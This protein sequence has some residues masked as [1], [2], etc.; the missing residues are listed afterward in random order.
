M[1]ETRRVSLPALL[2]EGLTLLL[3]VLGTLLSLQTGYS[4]PVE[5]AAL[6]TLGAGL[7]VGGMLLFHLPRFQ[8]LAAAV[9]LAA[10]GFWLWKDWEALSGGVLDLLDTAVAQVFSTG[11][12]VPDSGAVSL[13]L[14][15]ISV[16]WAGLLA[17]SLLRAR[18]A[19]LT[20]LL[21]WLPLVPAFCA[22][23]PVHWPGLVSLGAA[24]LSCLLSARPAG[25]EAGSAGARWRLLTLV[26]SGLLLGGL[27]W[28]SPEETYVYPQWADRANQWLTGHGG[29]MTQLLTGET[30][31][32][33]LDSGLSETV[34]LTQATNPTYTGASVLRVESSWTG[35]LYLRGYSM[36]VYDGESWTAVPESA[37]QAATGWAGPGG[38][39]DW[40]TLL[41][42]YPVLSYPAQAQAGQ[43]ET[44]T[45][46]DLGT[47]SDWVYTPYQLTGL[48][49]LEPQLDSTLLRSDGL[50]Q[51][52]FTWIPAGLDSLAEREDTSV[53]Q[54]EDLYSQFVQAQY[55]QLPEGLAEELAPYVEEAQALQLEAQSGQYQEERTAAAQV[56]G[57]LGQLAVYDLEAPLTPEGEEFTLYF[58]SQSQRGYCVHFATAGTLLLRAMGIPARYV[59]GYAAGVTVGETA[60]VP[61]SAAHAWVEIYLDGYG[62]YPVEMTPGAGGTAQIGQ[63]TEQDAEEETAQ[64]EEESETEAEPESESDGETETPETAQTESAAPAALWW[65]LGLAACAGA[66]W[67]G[68]RLWLAWQYRRTTQPD[69]NRAVLEI[70]GCFQALSRWGGEI[71]EEITALAQKARFSQHRLTRQEREE[72]RAKLQAG[73]RSAARRQPPWRRPLFWLVWDR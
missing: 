10:W 48:S 39:T 6:L 9:L 61:D 19:G 52:S 46:V 26:A 32:F 56:A 18:S 55:L 14:I 44:L 25:E 23:C 12:A 58:L 51:H 22:N 3:L 64:P 7:T 37:Y 71:P 35:L 15:L 40:L 8:W 31:I 36:G 42:N 73:I 67:G 54:A 1:D 21:A 62:W 65:V 53:S 72:A 2:L 68:R 47:P 66:L 4:L 24:S 30:T 50:W 57:L 16:P 38:E 59:A 20:L 60:L 49:D 70:Y 29:D 63:E 13:A 27:L 34:D 41:A 69:A 17:W 33:T 5:G 11:G 43:E 45:V 28:L